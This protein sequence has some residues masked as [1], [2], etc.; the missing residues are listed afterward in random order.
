MEWYMKYVVTSGKYQ[1][2]IRPFLWFLELIFCD[3]LSTIGQKY[4]LKA[5]FFKRDSFAKLFCAYAQL[6]FV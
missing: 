2:S 6:C 5:A 1:V 4:R 3:K